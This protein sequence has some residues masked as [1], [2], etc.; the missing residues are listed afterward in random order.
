[1]PPIPGHAMLNR[2][3]DRM[4]QAGQSAVTQEEKELVS[5]TLRFLRMRD[6]DAACCAA[7]GCQFDVWRERSQARKEFLN[8]EFRNVSSQAATAALAD[9]VRGVGLPDR[10]QRIPRDTSPKVENIPPMD[11]RDRTGREFNNGRFP[12]KDFKGSED[13]SG[14]SLENG[15]S[16]KRA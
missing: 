2:I 7:L 9:R 11:K 4:W 5:I 6:L 16:V 15:E 1:M 13:H 3:I 14:R 10:S 12:A 8:A